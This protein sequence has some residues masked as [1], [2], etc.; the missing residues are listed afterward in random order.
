MGDSD[1][2]DLLKLISDAGRAI[3]AEQQ[4]TERHVGNKIGCVHLQMQDVS[5]AQQFAEQAAAHS[6]LWQGLTQAGISLTDVNR[7]VACCQ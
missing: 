7:Q 3:A 6:T 5:V 4:G 1:L 2:Y